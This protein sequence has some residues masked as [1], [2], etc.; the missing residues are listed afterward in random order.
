[1]LIM[2][3]H[4]VKTFAGGKCAWDGQWAQRRVALRETQRGGY[5]DSTNAHSS[6]L[7]FFP[8]H[9]IVSIHQSI[10]RMEGTGSDTEMNGWMKWTSPIQHGCRYS[11]QLLTLTTCRSS[12]QSSTTTTYYW[13]PL[14]NLSCCAFLPVL[15]LI[16]A[17]VAAY[18]L[19]LISIGWRAN[20]S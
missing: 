12:T 6:N 18:S 1:M 10:N 3:V 16:K 15:E 20:Y 11:H 5:M 7:P 19:I 14:S 9:G 8:H 13:K 4:W 17:N 2:L